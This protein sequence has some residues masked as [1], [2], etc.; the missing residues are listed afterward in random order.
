MEN[1][2]LPRELL[3]EILARLP[4]NSLMRFKSV[5]K[6]F[7]CL[8]KSDHH[9][10]HKHYEI[11]QVRRDYA[12]F[13]PECSFT[14]RVF[15]LVYKELDSDEMGYVDLVMPSSEIDFVKCVDGILCLVSVRTGGTKNILI[16]NPSTRE[17]KELPPISTP[18][19]CRG[20]KEMIGFGFCNNMTGKVVIVWSGSDECEHKV[21]VCSQVD[22]IWVWREINPYPHFAHLWARL[23]VRPYQDIYFKGK[24]YWNFY[25]Y[26]ERGL[27]KPYLLWFDFS[28][29]IFGKIRMPSNPPGQYG[30]ERGYLLHAV[31][32]VMNDTIAYLGYHKKR[33]EVWLMMQNGSDVNWHKYA[34]IDRPREVLR[35]KRIWNQDRHV[36]I[37]RMGPKIDD[38]DPHLVSIDL[39]TGEIKMRID[40]INI[41]PDQFFLAY[42][43]SL[44]MF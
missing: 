40:N 1:C 29:E 2:T 27:F 39:V 44:K 24:Y 17:I 11:S 35:P 7:Y 21:M 42:N 20:L 3:I 4:V 38:R 13:G 5:C 41:H 6:F 34:C 19:S 8:I 37:Y 32:S 18:H 30:N 28:A 36:L 43:E 22:N 15:G 25:A 12:V 26:D 14:P 33:W 31:V 10:Q 23:W 16:W 9:F